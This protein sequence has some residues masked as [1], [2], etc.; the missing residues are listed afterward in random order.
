MIS[1]EEAA[2]PAHMRE[3][4]SCRKDVGK[5]ESEGS[6]FYPSVFHKR[7]NTSADLYEYTLL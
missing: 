7:R 5:T 1:L 3:R 4:G 6:S 2:V